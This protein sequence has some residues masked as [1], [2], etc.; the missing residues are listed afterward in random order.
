MNSSET[1]SI[2]SMKFIL[3]VFIFFVFPCFGEE[4]PLVIPL[5]KLNIEEVKRF[6]PSQSAKNKGHTLWHATALGVEPY[7]NCAKDKHIVY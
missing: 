1:E 3:I 2:F 5:Y 7:K 6:A 4:N